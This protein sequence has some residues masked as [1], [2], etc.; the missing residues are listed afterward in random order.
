MV[1]KYKYLYVLKIIKAS[2]SNIYNKNKKMNSKDKNK[3]KRGQWSY[4]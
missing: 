2:W 1:K 3:E 4:K